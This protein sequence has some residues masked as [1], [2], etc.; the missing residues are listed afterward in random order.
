MLTNELTDKRG[1][2]EGETVA[3]LRFDSSHLPFRTALNPQEVTHQQ[4]ITK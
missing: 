3:E 4:K 1:E 2:Q